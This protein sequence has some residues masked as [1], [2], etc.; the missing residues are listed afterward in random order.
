MRRFVLLFASYLLVGNLLLLLPP[1]KNRFVGPWTMLNAR[2]AVAMAG[3][4]GEE[5]QAVG[6]F[7][8]VGTGGLSVKPGCN[9]VHALI[10]C[11]VAI[12]A[13]PASWGRRLMGVGLSTAGVFGLN[14]IRLVNLFYVARYFPERLEFFHVYVWQTLI[15]LLAFGIFLGW[16]RF[17][18]TSPSN[19]PAAQG[20]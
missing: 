4:G 2:W 11:I 19:A 15:A 1:V 3:W 14:L 17:L 13:F 18:A 5:F 9:G 20:A 7:V 10:L 6:S 8:D 12:L 16:G